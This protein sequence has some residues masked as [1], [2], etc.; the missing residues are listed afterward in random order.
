MI[1]YQVFIVRFITQKLKYLAEKEGYIINN[2]FNNR[3]K[4]K[5]YS[6]YVDSDFL[7]LKFMCHRGCFRDD[8]Y[9]KKCILCKKENNSIKNE[10]NE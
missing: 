7:L 6:W 9:L 5:I 10:I 2:Q 4:N 8:I 3:L 1:Y